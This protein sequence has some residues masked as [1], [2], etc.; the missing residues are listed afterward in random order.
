[1]GDLATTLQAWL[2]TQ[3]GPFVYVLITI[4]GAMEYVFPPFPGDGTVLFAFVLSTGKGGLLAPVVF[5]CSLIGSTGGG[6]FAWWLGN[7]FSKRGIPARLDTPA[8][9]RVLE[10]V[11]MRFEKSSTAFL[12]ANRFIPVLRGVAYLGA[13][14]FGVSLRRS[15]LLGSISSFLWNASLFAVAYLVHGVWNQAN[16]L[17]REVSIWVGVAT[18]A[19]V[20][21]FGGYRWLKAKRRRQS[22]LPLQAQPP[23]P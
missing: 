12:I 21:I 19:G 17:L 13:G 15:L 11:R 6:L 14:Y 22:A 20:L 2:E 1:M 8:L 10:R 4:A 5:A 23:L 16:A 9:R 3:T 18:V 7:V